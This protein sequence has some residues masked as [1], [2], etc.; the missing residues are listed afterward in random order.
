MNISPG[1]DEATK[2]RLLPGV[3]EIASGHH[4]G[5]QLESL[6]L[7]IELVTVGLRCAT[8]LDPDSS[9]CQE[10]ERIGLTHLR[11]AVETTQW[12]VM[13]ALV[14]L[15]AGSSGLDLEYCAVHP[16]AAIRALAAIR[17]AKDPTVFPH[18]R[19]AELAHD[20]D[21]QVRLAL[22]QAL[23]S[24]DAAVTTRDE[25]DRHDLEARRTA[26]RTNA[27]TAGRCVKNGRVNA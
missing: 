10:I 9:T 5:D 17:W 25:R 21:Y 2:R 12:E 24:S 11:A 26:K 6:G 14:L 4:A 1:L 23:Q 16:W 19:A 13:R 15:P 27:S 7:R 3:M 22:A 20:S 8:A 18:E